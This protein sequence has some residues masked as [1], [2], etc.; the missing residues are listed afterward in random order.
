MVEI[1]IGQTKNRGERSVERS[2]RE[3]DSQGKTMSIATRSDRQEDQKKSSGERDNAVA[4]RTVCSKGA[5]LAR[6]VRWL[7]S[8]QSGEGKSFPWPNGNR[9]FAGGDESIQ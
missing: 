3:H 2:R 4:V 6:V 7:G 8:K 9:V 1:V 5:I